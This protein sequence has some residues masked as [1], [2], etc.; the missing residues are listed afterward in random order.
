MILYVDYSYS[1]PNQCASVLNSSGITLKVVDGAKDIWCR[2]YLPVRATDGT[3]VQFR[4]EPSYMEDT[5]HL[6]SDPRV[7]NP[8][9]GFFPIYSDINLD[10]GNVVR[11]GERVII[12]D[13]IFTEN[14]DRAPQGLIRELEALLQAEVLIFPSMRSDMTGHADGMVRFYNEKTLLIACRANEYLFWQKS[15]DRFVRRYG[16]D[17]IDVPS[18]IYSERGVPSYHAIGCYINFLQAGN[19][20]AVPQFNCPGNRD[21]EALALFTKLYPEA[22]VFG[23]PSFEIARE[24][25]VLNCVTW[26]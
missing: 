26:N 9:N 10:G 13:R 24:G 4:Y 15:V 19:C 16:F 1:L 2:D 18:F 21:E 17:V 11:Y 12:S 8:A 6:R 22:T 5:P 23:I 7:V 20:I 25:G 14:P 3:L